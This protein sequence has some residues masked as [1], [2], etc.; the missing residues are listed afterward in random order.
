MTFSYVLFFFCGVVCG[1]LAYFL[2]GVLLREPRVIIASNCRNCNAKWKYQ[3]LIPLIGYFLANR[4]CPACGKD[5]RI[6]GLLIEIIS[7]IIFVYFFWK[8][9][10]TLDLAIIILF[11]FILI[12]LFI[13]DLEDMLLPNLVTY[14]ALLVVMAI[15]LA[16]MLFNLQPAWFIGFNFTG[17]AGLINNPLVSSLAGGLTGFILLFIVALLSKGGMAFGD[18]KL[19]ALIGMMVGFPLVFVALFIGI[20]CGG[21]I[22]LILLLMRRKGRKEFIPFGP[23]LCI[24]GISALLWGANILFWYLGIG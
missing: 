1:S 12:L 10:F 24:G 5:L 2:A 19:A 15:A 21:M 6:H 20:M 22:A 3:L 11:Y 23:F 16:L 17:W 13:T 4:K 9:N 18:V 14:P 7:G 8:Y